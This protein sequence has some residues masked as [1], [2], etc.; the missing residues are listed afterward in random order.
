MVVCAGCARRMSRPCL[1]PTSIRA[2]FVAPIAASAA[3]RAIVDFA[4]NF[5]RKSST[6][7]ASWSVTTRL[8]H[9]RPVSCRR[10]A[11]FLDTFIGDP[12]ELRGAARG[13]LP[14]GPVQAVDLA[15]HGHA[16]VPHPPATRPLR[17]Q[18]GTRR[19]R[20]PQ[21]EGV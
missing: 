14:G 12:V 6:A 4:R 1:R 19:G 10:W 13:L 18:T 20:H 17:L 16:L 9:L 3:L 21:L 15:G 11:I 8:A 7:I 5:G 2:L